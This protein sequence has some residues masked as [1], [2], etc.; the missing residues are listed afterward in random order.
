MLRYRRSGT[1]GKWGLWDER[2]MGD[3]ESSGEDVLNI[4]AC[5][6]KYAIASSLGTFFTKG[7]TRFLRIIS[8]ASLQRPRTS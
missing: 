8:S 4:V 1:H 6:S 3:I 5:Q 2:G 7:S